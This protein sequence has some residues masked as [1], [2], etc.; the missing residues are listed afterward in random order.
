MVLYWQWKN[1]KN[2]GI[3]NRHIELIVKNDQVKEDVAKR[4]FEELINQNVIAI[5]VIQAVVCLKLVHK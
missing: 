5:I 2:G 4:V 3:N 1:Y